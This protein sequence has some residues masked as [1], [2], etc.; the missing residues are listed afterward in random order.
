MMTIGFV[1]ERRKGA[2]FFACMRTSVKRRSRRPE[3][4]TVM[5]AVECVRDVHALDVAAVG[6]D[7]LT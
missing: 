2:S 4:V 7:V 6:A 3:T 1:C 5:R